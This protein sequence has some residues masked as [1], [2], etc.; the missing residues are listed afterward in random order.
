MPWDLSAKAQPFDREKRLV[1]L[2]WPT[3]AETMVGMKRLDNLEACIRDVCYEDIPGDF[4]ETGVWRGGCAILMRSVLRDLD[5]DR[6][7]WLADSFQGLPSPDVIRYPADAGD[8]HSTLTPYLC[9]SLDQVKA[10]FGRY[11]LLDNQVKFLPGWF[12]DTLPSAPIDRL[13]LMRLDGD[14]YESTM[15]ALESLYPK[16]SSGGYCIVDDYALARCKQAVTDYREAHRITE[17]MEPVDWTGVY[18]Q[19]Q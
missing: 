3:E 16:L 17:P 19:K 15:I 11:E 13:A 4:I 5:E 10:N 12:R 1:G 8:V 6:T 14:M 9:V 7:V 2:D 18:W